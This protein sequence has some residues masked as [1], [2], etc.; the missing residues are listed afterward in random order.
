V[1]CMMELMSTVSTVLTAALVSGVVTIGLEVVAKPRLDARKERILNDVR[2]RREFESNLLRLRM[3]SGTWAVFEYPPNVTDEG[4]ALLDAERERAFQRMDDVTVELIDNLGFYALTYFGMSL[5][6]LHTSVPELISRYVF[7]VRGVLLSNRS[8]AA[9]AQIIQELTAPIHIYLFGSKWHPVRRG[10]ALVELPKVLDKYESSDSLLAERQRPSYLRLSLALIDF[11]R[12][13][14]QFGLPGI[15]YQLHRTCEQFNPIQY[16]PQ[17]ERG[18][19][20]AA[21]ISD[22]FHRH[23]LVSRRFIFVSKILDT[24]MGC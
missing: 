15:I 13:T 10:K 14:H 4:R 3:T 2:N 20:M 8:F 17:W 5:P 19:L 18:R 11:S 1:C 22:P 21:Y 23:Q 16:E 9:K 6:R 7:A 12:T 24:L